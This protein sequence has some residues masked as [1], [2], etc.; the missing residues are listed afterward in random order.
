MEG[1]EAMMTVAELIAKLGEYPEDTIVVTSQ[2]GGDTN[3]FTRDVVVSGGYFTG[4]SEFIGDDEDEDPEDRYR[5]KRG[6]VV[7]VAIQ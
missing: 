5:P 1:G 6:D 4:R 2:G 3:Y 7:A